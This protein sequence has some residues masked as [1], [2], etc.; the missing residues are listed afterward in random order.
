VKALCLSEELLLPDCG[1]KEVVAASQLAAVRQ[2]IRPLV[3][4]KT[5]APDAPPLPQKDTLS[6]SCAEEL[7]KESNDDNQLTGDN[8]EERISK[9]RS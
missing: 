8:D 3:K 5:E 7:E 9:N 2:D 6:D 4:Q 1:V